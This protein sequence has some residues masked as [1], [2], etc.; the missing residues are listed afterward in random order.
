MIPLAS[1]SLFHKEVAVKKDVVLPQDREAIQKQARL[2]TFNSADLAKGIISGDWAIE[3]VND[4]KAVGESAPFLRFVPSEGRIYGNNGCNTVNAAYKSNPADSTLSFSEIATTMRMCATEGLTDYE[5][6]GA[7]DRTRFYSWELVGSEYWLYLYNDAHIR[8]MSLMHQSFDFLNGTWRVTAIEDQPVDIPDMKLVFDID[9]GKVHGNTG[10]NIIN[11]TIETDM[12]KP[13]SISLQDFAMTR[14]ACP[15]PEYQTRLIV[16]LEDASRAKPVSPG[17]VL[18][19]DA[20]G[21]VVLT[22]QREN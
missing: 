7:L 20:G 12:E 17:K 22:L 3:E 16:A 8:V 5:I 13:N 15:D 9:E 2:K 21:T 10:C 4:K 18:L 19:L 14:M 11:G 1:C 6:N